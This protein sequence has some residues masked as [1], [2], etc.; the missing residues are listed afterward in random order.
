MV[1]GLLRGDGSVGGKEARM[2]GYNAVLA[3]VPAVRELFGERLASELAAM[4]ACHLC[5]VA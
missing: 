4:E 2:M 5:C 1:L 3:L